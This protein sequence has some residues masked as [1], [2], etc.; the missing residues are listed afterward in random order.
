MKGKIVVVFFQT[1]VCVSLEPKTSVV[2]LVVDGETIVNEVRN[3][4]QKRVTT[5]QTVSMEKI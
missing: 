5:I 3:G 1:R 4:V 2:K